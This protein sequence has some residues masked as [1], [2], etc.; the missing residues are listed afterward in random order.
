MV[1]L[2][3]TTYAESRLSPCPFPRELPHGALP[4]AFGVVTAW[5]CD[6]LDPSPAENE[7]ATV[8]RLSAI[9][10]LLSTIPS[11]PPPGPSEYCPRTVPS[12]NIARIFTSRSTSQLFDLEDGGQEWIRT[13]EGVSQ[14]I[15]SLPRL[16]TSVP[17]LKTRSVREANRARIMERETGMQ[18]DC[19]H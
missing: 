5:N 13:I 14:Q 6:A 12:D 18:V 11:F 15:Y 8:R 19:R 2:C 1:N 10:Q 17:T 9:G 3:Q 4:A 7:A 16:A